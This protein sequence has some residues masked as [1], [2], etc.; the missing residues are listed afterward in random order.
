MIQVA[1]K[2]CGQTSILLK[3]GDVCLRKFDEGRKT[4]LGIMEPVMDSPPPRSAQRQQK[5]REKP[6]AK[7]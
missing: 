3:S 7:G 5:S 1:C 4:C 2:E 6:K